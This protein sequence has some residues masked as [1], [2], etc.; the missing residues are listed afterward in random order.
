MTFPLPDLVYVVGAMLAVAILVECVWTPRV[1]ASL[2]S[3]TKRRMERGPRYNSDL[4]PWRRT[5]A[6][7]HD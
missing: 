7:R 4:L 2:T 3:M 6:A 1:R 5:A